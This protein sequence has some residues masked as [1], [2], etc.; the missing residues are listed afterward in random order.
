MAETT[1]QS[2]TREVEGANGETREQTQFEA[3][4]PKSL[5]EAMEW[6]PGRKLKWEVETGERLSVEQVDHDK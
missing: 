6:D 4:V 5:V 3:T 1:L 2:T